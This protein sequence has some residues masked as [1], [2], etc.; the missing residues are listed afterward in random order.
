MNSWRKA[1]ISFRSTVRNRL[2]GRRPGRLKRRQHPCADAG[3]DG[4]QSRHEVSQKACGIVIPF[5]Q[6]QP[7]DRSLRNRRPIR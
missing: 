3:R 5:V 2:G 4:L 7:S 1:A 6:R